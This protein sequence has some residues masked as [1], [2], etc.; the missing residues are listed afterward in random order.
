MIYISFKNLRKVIFCDAIRCYIGVYNFLFL[1]SSIETFYIPR[2]PN[3]R[4]LLK[5]RV[6]LIIIR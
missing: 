4:G 2:V 1:E 5:S 6:I 3:Q